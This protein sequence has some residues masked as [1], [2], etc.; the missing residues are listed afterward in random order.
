MPRMQYLVSFALLVAVGA[1]IVGVYNN[2]VHLRGAVCRSWQQW[3]QATHR[4]NECLREFATALAFLMKKDAPQ[5]HSLLRMAADSERSLALAEAPRWTSVHGFM[6][7]AEK[8]LRL[9]IMQAERDLEDSAT[10]RED[11][12]LLQLYSSVVASLYQQ[13]QCSALFNRAA[14]EYNNALRGASARFLAPVFGFAAAD[15]LDAAAAEQNTRSS[16]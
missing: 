8:L 2:L 4:R 12:Q 5:P 13:D 14:F 3:R 9:E 6:G 7:R 10:L 16:S 1:W 11:E 15:P